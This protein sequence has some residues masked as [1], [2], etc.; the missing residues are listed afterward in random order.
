MILV[1]FYLWENARVIE[2]IP[3]M[4]TATIQDQQPVFL[5]PESPQGVLW[6]AAAVT[7]GFVATASFIY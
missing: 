2:I 1:L 4:G 7:D 3:L 5:H 6:G